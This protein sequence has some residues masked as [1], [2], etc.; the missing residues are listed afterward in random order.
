MYPAANDLPPVDPSPYRSS[1]SPFGQISACALI[2]PKFGTSRLST[3][4]RTTEWNVD[5][6]VCLPLD[7]PQCKYTT[8]CP[9]T[10]RMK[11]WSLS[12][13]PTLVSLE[14]PSAFVTHTCVTDGSLAECVWRQKPCQPR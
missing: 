2:V 3:A 14:A 7:S 9:T 4:A 13:L 11:S 12:V 6:G 1:M 10:P 5:C 8:V